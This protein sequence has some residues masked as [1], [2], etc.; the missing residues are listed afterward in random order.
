MVTLTSERVE[1][2]SSRQI[3]QK[4]QNSIKANLEK[5]SRAGYL[6]IQRRLHKLDR[7]WTTERAIEVEAPLMIAFGSGLTY[8]FG[9]KFLALPIFSAS[10]LLLHGIKGWYPL[11]PLFRRM[12][13]RSQNEIL[14]E[15]RGLLEL[16]DKVQLTH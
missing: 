13:L 14:Q 12:G 16:K 1:A 9:R 6:A 2:N 11:L 3:N 10:M 15:R 4:I 7:E 8:F 5:Y